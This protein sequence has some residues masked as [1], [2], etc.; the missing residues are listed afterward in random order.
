ML[1]RLI[2]FCFYI[3]ILNVNAQ[4]TKVK[5]KNQKDFKYF[6]TE[7]IDSAKINRLILIRVM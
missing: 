3:N 2:I 7:V 6:W 5:I 4:T 1:T